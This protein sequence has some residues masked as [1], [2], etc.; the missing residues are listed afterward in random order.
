[1]ETTSMSSNFDLNCYMPIPAVALQYR[2]I[3]VPE[4]PAAVTDTR[5]PSRESADQPRRPNEIV[6]TEQELMERIRKET[7]DAVRAVEERMRRETE[8]RVNE[9]RARMQTAVSAFEAQKDLYFAKVEA[10]VV[11]L[12]L[13]I[14]AKIIHREAQVDPMLLTA[15]VKVALE[16][17][18]EG[19]SVTLKVSPSQAKVFSTVFAKR[20]GV[21][22]PEVIAD[23]DLSES[24]CI[25][26]SELGIADIG[27]NAQLKEVEQ[28]FFDLLAL[29]PASR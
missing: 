17:M 20:D 13:A 10:E 9:E 24:D 27:L 4:I 23:P 2:N 25:L 15:L 6:L 19:S 28:G 11:Q 21:S 18:R 16:R 3:A 26:E 14:A 1:M 29:R 12:S 7:S 8:T 22:G 5:I